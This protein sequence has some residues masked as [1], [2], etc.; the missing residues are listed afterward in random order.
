MSKGCGCHDSSAEQIY[1]RIDFR[2]HKR[3]HEGCSD[4][5]YK[6]SQDYFSASEFDEQVAGKDAR[7]QVER[8]AQKYEPSGLAECLVWLHIECARFFQKEDQ[9]KKDVGR[10]GEI[11]EKHSEH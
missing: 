3:N 9:Y 4:A 1:I 10:K 11:C 6:T 8:V 7:D 2:F 5:K